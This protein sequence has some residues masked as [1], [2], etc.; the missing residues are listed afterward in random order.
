MEM[1]VMNDKLLKIKKSSHAGKIVANILCIIC[2]VGC[3]CC[4]IGGAAILS[5]ADKL[6]GQF[7]EM[8]EDG[9]FDPSV[10][11]IASV[12]MVSFESVDPDK[13]ESDVPA[14]QNALDDHPYCFIYGMYIFMA[15]G[16]LAVVA[17]LMKLVNGTFALIEKEDNPFTDKVIRR[18]VIVLAVISGLILM[19]SGAAMGVLGALVT[20]VVY[21]VLDYGKT[22]Q[23][24][25]DETL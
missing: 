10:N 14:I 7:Q 18:V 5:G 4:L 2:I 19:T 13:W 9:R 23:I 24:Q 20:W 16:I 17:V 21:T 8:T 15:A 11:R 6:E 1:N 12:R 25:A 3:V 22:L